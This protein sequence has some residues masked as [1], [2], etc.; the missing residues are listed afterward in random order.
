MLGDPVCQGS[1]LRWFVRV[2]LTTPNAPNVKQVFLGL[3]GN[4]TIGLQL[5]YYWQVYP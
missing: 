5:A 2:A 3:T 4:D 1:H